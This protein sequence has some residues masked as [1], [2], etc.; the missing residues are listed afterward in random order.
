MLARIGGQIGR[1]E[2][3]LQGTQHE[4]QRRAELV[5]DIREE[6]S[7]G[8]IN[9]CQCFSA[10]ALRVVGSDIRDGC[11]DMPG[12]QF[13]KG[14]VVRVQWAA[15]AKARYQKASASGMPGSRNGDDQ[16]LPRGF[17]PDTA[18]QVSKYFRCVCD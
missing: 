18:G 17:G 3:I 15:R 1:A 10:L 4:C 11:A 8:L 9:L 13:Q 5:A 14:A 6:L 12:D 2:S 7:F 16:S